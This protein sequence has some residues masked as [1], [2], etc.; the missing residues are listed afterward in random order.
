MVQRSAWVG[1]VKCVSGGVKG[2]GSHVG[3]V[4]GVLWAACVGVSFTEGKEVSR[5]G[6]G[7]RKFVTDVEGK[8]L[9]GS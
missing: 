2:E 1:R 6:S 8:I 4:G 3:V 5:E 9:I 7:C